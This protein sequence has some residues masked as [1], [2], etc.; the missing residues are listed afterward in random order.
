MPDLMTPQQ[1]LIMNLLEEKTLKEVAKLTG[2]SVSAV[3]KI[4]QNALKA[5]NKAK[6]YTIYQELY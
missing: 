2:Y 6:F 1:L 4:K 5:S 3:Q